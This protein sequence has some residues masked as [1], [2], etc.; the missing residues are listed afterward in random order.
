[1]HW[2]TA[3]FSKKPKFLNHIVHRKPT[4]C[5]MHYSFTLHTSQGNLCPIQYVPQFGAHPVQPQPPPHHCHVTMSCP[6]PGH[7]C[8]LQAYRAHISAITY[9]SLQQVFKCL[10][11]LWLACLWNIDRAK[12]RVKWRSYSPAWEGP[13][14]PPELAARLLFTAE[15]LVIISMM[16]SLKC[17]KGTHRK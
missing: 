10:F 12:E 17:P 13:F 8:S 2:L 5:L 11:P 3:S 1:M 7:G 15:T 9:V 14:W 16:Q 6:C 4:V